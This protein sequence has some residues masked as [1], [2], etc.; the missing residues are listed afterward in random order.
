MTVTAAD[1]SGATAT[2]SV[3]ITVT[4]VSLGTLADS[5]DAD[6]NETISRDEVIQ[7]IQDHLN[8]LITREQ[9]QEI[10]RL[11]LFR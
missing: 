7:A 11:Y 8:G 4:D 9:V 5:Y 3:T 6:H 10:I 1:P 2:T